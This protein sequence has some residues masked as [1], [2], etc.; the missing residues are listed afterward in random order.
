MFTLIYDNLLIEAEHEGLIVKEKPLQG[1]DGRIKGERIAIRKD[2]PTLSQKSC[3]LAEELGHHY[4]TVGNIIDMQD[5]KN[6]KQERQARIWA[7][8]K[9]IG[10]TGIIQVHRH[11]CTTRHE[12][13]ED[14]G[15]TEEF[16]QEAIDYYT[17]KYGDGARLIDGYYIIFV[18]VLTVV[19]AVH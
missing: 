4:T 10:L 13:A 3:V 19:E 9:L 12:M 8:D 7:Y 16:L 1:A 2:I 15:V 5:I 6:V 14:L 17:Q 11:H 18:P